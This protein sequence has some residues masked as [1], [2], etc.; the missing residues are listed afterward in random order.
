MGNLYNSAAFC[1]VAYHHDR[2]LLCHGVARMADRGIPECVLQDEENNPLAQRS[3]QGNVKAA[4]LEGDPRCPNL[5]ASSVYDTK[6]LNCLSMVSESI[7]WVEKEKMV[8]KVDTG[9]VEALKLLRLNQID[10]YKN[11][12]GDVD[13]AD[14]IRGI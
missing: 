5:I 4:V 1:R 6:P 11:E 9:K 7:Q 12:M 3:A 13:V 2:K 10:K 8:Y 14:K